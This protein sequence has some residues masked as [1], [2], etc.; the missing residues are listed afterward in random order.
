M[1]TVRSESS[2]N[3]TVVDYG[4][5][6]IGSVAK[7]LSR[8]NVTFCVSSNSSDLEAADRLI[9]P[10]VGAFDKAMASLSRLKLDS[11]IRR[12]VIEFNKPLLGICLGMQLLCKTSTEGGNTEGLSLFDAAVLKMKG[13]KDF[14]LPHIGWNALKK[15]GCCSLTS[16]LSDGSFMYF[17]HDYVVHCNNKNDVICSTN[18]GQRFPSVIN[19]QNIFGV[20]F[21]PEKSQRAGS[22]IMTNFVLGGVS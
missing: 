11:C 5:G 10:G 15:E 2:L 3:V 12:Q 19:H 14:R 13:G 22:I 16:G 8:L 4:M 17:A 9:L 18:Y 6:N 1:K 21:H 7:V 20:Q